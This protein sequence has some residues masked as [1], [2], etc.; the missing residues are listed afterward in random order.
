[1]YQVRAK[2]RLKVQVL[3]AVC[4]VFDDHFSFPYFLVSSQSYI[5]DVHLYLLMEL[6]T[7]RL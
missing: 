5:H 4:R 3:N 2:T 7:C 1:M 6:G